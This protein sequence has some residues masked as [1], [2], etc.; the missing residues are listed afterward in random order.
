MTRRP[1]LLV[2]E[3]WGVG[4]LAVA[5]PFLRT[6]S[7][8]FEVTLLAKPHAL[9]LRPRLWPSV[10]VLTLDAPWTTF[11][12]KYQL[13]KWP[14]RELAVLR[15]QLAAAQFAF[16]ISARHDPRDHFFLWLAGVQST[17]G[18]P[19]LGSEMLLTHPLPAPR[20]TVHRYDVWRQL[21]QPLGLELP[22]RENLSVPPHP[23]K[24]ILL[25]SGARLDPRVWPLDRYLALAARLRAAGHTVQVACDTRQE[26]WWR[27]HG[28]TGITTPPSLEELFALLDTAAA[29]VGN[30]SGP[31]HL[32][33]VSGV[34][35][36]TIFGPSQP[37]EFL[38]VHPRADFIEDNSCPH[39]PCADYCKFDSPRCL[40]NLPLEVVAARVK[41]FLSRLK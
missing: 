7:E 37:G 39:K 2:L 10:N 12:G 22:A 29:F 18:L 32:A 33:A 6:A 25:H 28:E 1:K 14:W 31:G 21:A 26:K 35:T 8:K 5:T 4:D 30:C 34:P 19:R 17:V 3:L 23:G 20:A 41:A 15:A 27:D 11:R 13:A 16:G 9:A 40:E 36:F 24:N 38:P